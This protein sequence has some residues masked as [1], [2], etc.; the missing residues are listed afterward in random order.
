MMSLTHVEMGIEEGLQTS[1]AV[2]SAIRRQAVVVKGISEIVK[3]QDAVWPDVGRDDQIDV[4]I[5]DLDRVTVLG[6]VGKIDVPPAV[7]GSWSR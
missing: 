2:C 1:Q 6:D 4:L 7:P 5:H 3:V